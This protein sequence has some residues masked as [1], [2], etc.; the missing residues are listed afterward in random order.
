MGEPVAIKAYEFDPAQLKHATMK[1]NK[2]KTDP[3]KETKQVRMTYGPGNS[4]LRVKV[5]KAR[6][7]FGLTT[8]KDDDPSKY[9]KYS[10][11]I[12]L[13][14]ENP[15]LV[16]FKEMLLKIDA[17]NLKQTMEKCKE[18]FG[19]AKISADAA[20]ERYE[21]M[22]KYPKEEGS[23]YAPTFKIKLNVYKGD[24]AFR[25]YNDKNKKMKWVSGESPN[26]ELD[27][28]WADKKSNVETVIDCEGLYI[29]GKKVY[30]CW[31]AYQIKSYPPTED[32]C[33]FGTEE[34]EEEED[35]E[36]SD[37]NTVKEVKVIKEESSPKKAPLKV[38]DDSSS[39]DEE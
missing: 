4:F 25:L 27:W 9:K 8:S 11:S 14:D 15:E 18:W 35:A 38:E 33:L 2:S 19:D 37:E 20:K 28:S 23:T 17:I 6:L 26:T 21:S 13:D 29:V 24:P 31:R 16:K 30:C 12:S 36:E 7:P 10:I 34:G 3:S 32:D 39:E 1:A 22:I 5:A